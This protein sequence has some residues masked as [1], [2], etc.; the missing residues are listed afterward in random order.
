MRA[1]RPPVLV[2]TCEHGG[3]EFPPAYA[4]LFESKRARAALDSHRGVD[5]GA[6]EV[7]M[8]MAAIL[9]VPLIAAS[10]SRLLVDL[11]RSL[12]HP[13]LFSEFSR[14]L[15]AEAR[16]QVLAE[17]YQ[18]HRARVIKAVERAVTSGGFCFHVGV[19]SF[20]PVLNGVERHAD[21]G[22]L[23]D[24]ARAAEA[25][26]CRRWQRLASGALRVRRNYP[27]RG[28]ADGLTTALRRRFSSSAYAG[29]ELEINQARLLATPGRIEIAE[30]AA[31]TLS[32]A[33]DA[34]RETR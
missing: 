11:N 16:T 26:L 28:V 22:L 15:S 1:A 34:S 4:D 7:A 24:P 3:N 6:A 30:R 27:Y 32:A 10:T 18:P 25:A 8:R 33:L 31:A 19:H 13:Q 5:I 2:L 9:G 17:I 23:Y 29:I 14:A 12:R 21:L 20:T